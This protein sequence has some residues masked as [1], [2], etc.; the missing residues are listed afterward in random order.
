MNKFVGWAAAAALVSG[1]ASAA[2]HYSV[3][4]LELPGDDTSAAERINNLG[5]VVG[6]SF[7]RAQNRNRTFFFDGDATNDLLPG[8]TSTSQGI[9]D[10]SDIAVNVTSDC[11]Q[12]LLIT[13]DG[14]RIELGTRYCGANELGQG[15]TWVYGVNGTRQAVGITNLF[16]EDGSYLATHAA[17]WDG[18][19]VTDLGTLGG[20]TSLAT[21]INE[22]GVVAGYSNLA[23]GYAMH[24]FIFA[25]GQMK[26][27]GTLGGTL[28]YPTSINCDGLVVGASYLADGTWHAYLYDGEQM[29]DLGTLPKDVHSHAYSINSSGMVVGYSEDGRTFKGF[30]SDGATMWDLNELTAGSGWTIIDARGINDAGQIAAVASGYWNGSW[31]VRAVL[32]TPLDG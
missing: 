25:D 9:N 13:G 28:S 1:A 20:Q 16:R 4:V 21:A 3:Q 12:A 31:V 5:Q 27:L 8:D 7:N 2:P 23:E 15:I 11:R 24:A 29:R 30:L 14:D 32:L 6:T 10:G 17:V 19:V 26:D 18:G 22:N